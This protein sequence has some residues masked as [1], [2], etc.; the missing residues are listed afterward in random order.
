MEVGDGDAGGKD[1]I[2]RVLGGEVCC[3]LSSEILTRVE[4]ALHRK[5][6]DDTY[7]ELYCCHALVHAGDDFLCDSEGCSA[8]RNNSPS[9]HILD[10]IDMIW[11]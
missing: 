7:V 5:E 11:I 10:R 2:V 4:S 8:A 3:C 6:K 9:W 1:S